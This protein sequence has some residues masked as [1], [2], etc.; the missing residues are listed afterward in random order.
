[1]MN[2][3]VK[4]DTCWLFRDVEESDQEQECLP[5][6]ASSPD[7]D[8]GLLR[9]Q[10]ESSEWK[11]LAIVDK[12]VMSE[13]GLRSRVEEL[14][15]SERKLLH[16][17]EQL[18]ARMAQE[19]SASLCAQEQ[20]QAL[21]RELVSQGAFGCAQSDSL[22]LPRAEVLDPCSSRGCHSDVCGLQALAGRSCPAPPR[23]T[24]S[25]AAV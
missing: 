17:V 19:R 2:V 1:M 5:E 24:G 7:L 8:T 9:E 16:K 15:L 11:L 4:T 20:L 3:D 6:A 12:H 14:E 23:R 10:L 13:S 21:Q 18:N 25:S 22:P